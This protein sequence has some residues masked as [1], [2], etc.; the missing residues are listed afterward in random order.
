MK[1]ASDAATWAAIAISAGGGLITTAIH[2]GSTNTKIEDIQRAQAD[3]K[4][5]VDDH[6]RQLAAIQASQ[7][8]NAQA[9]V[10]IKDTVHDI[11]DKVSKPK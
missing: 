4:A 5:A 9:L 3:Q 11:Q 1:L 7:A 8:A 2:Y 6:T 10:D